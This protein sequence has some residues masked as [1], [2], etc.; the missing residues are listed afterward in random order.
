MADQPPDDLKD[1]SLPDLLKQLSQ[2]T[3][4]LVR[5]ELELVKAEIR[6]TG[7]KGA[8]GAGM[9]GAAGIV[10]LLALGTF[11]AFLILLLGDLFDNM[12]LAALIVTAVYGA[13]ATVLAL[14][15]KDK[16]QDATPPAPQTVETVK[17]D[18]EWAKHPTTSGGR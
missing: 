17:E 15:G 18:I 12:W 4:T 11:T 2:E 5:Q 7:K 8:K 9:F 1:R 14:Q 16:I 10:G 3:A 6:Q 13:V